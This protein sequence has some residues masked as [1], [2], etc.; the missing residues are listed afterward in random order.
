MA[1]LDR[2]RPLAARHCATWN[3]LWTWRPPRVAWAGRQQRSKPDLDA[4]GST[5]R[6]YEERPREPPRESNTVPRPWNA[7]RDRQPTMQTVGGG[8]IWGGAG[9]PP[10]GKQKPPQQTFFPPATRAPS[11]YCNEQMSMH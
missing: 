9:P 8:I 11:G 4:G 1:Q 5:L 2:S 3:V 6:S 7:H 10:P